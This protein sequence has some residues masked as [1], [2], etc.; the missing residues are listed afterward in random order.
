MVLVMW[1]LQL[2]V[3]MQCVRCVVSVGGD[4]VG[5][6]GDDVACVVCPHHQQNSI[7]L[8]CLAP[9]EPDTT[10]VPYFI[11]RHIDAHDAIKIS[12]LTN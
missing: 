6:I 8:A 7:R 2:S 3:V 10:S 5:V 9:D 12:Q 1:R 11:W 4:M